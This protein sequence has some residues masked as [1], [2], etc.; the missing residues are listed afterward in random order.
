MKKIIYILIFI[1]FGSSTILGQTTTGYV[2]VTWDPCEPC[3]LGMKYAVCITIERV[4]DHYVVTE[5]QC[6]TLTSGT[7]HQF[8]F[9]M[10]QC[11]SNWD[12]KV[13]A[14]VW[15]GC[16]PSSLCCHGKNSGTLATCSELENGTADDVY[17]PYLP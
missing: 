10:P 13:Y 11:T 7:S 9:E 2:T 12:F 15:A 14:T 3:C 5:N 6:D 1:L 16:P 17:V 8:S 4:Y